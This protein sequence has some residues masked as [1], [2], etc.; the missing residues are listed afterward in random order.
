MKNRLTEEHWN[1]NVKTKLA[2]NLSQLDANIVWSGILD[3]KPPNGTPMRRLVAN[4]LY[5]PSVLLLR[6]PAFEDLGNL[7]IILGEKYKLF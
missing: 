6:T 2:M 3:E 1:M 4:T 7:E 5:F